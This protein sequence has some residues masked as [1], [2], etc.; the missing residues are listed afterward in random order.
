M[1]EIDSDNFSME[2]AKV[3][4][5][6]SGNGN[7]YNF[8]GVES[9]SI[10]NKSDEDIKSALTDSD[11]VFIIAGVQTLNVAKIAK[12]I[13]ALTVAIVEKEI[14]SSD[15]DTFFVVDD[16]N[17]SI[18]QNI[19]KSISDLIAVPGLINLDVTDVKDILGNAGRAYS[20]TGEA[21][22]TTDAVK[23]AIKSVDGNISNSKSLLLNLLGATDGLSMMEVN[24]AATALQ[25]AVNEDAEI[26]WGVSIEESLGDK[27]IATVIAARCD[28]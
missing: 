8:D 3:K 23:N 4:L 1:F 15:I 16:K 14:K 26:I 19:I 24:D 7:D 6:Y 17:K 9:V 22:N 5:A 10:D 18:F 27:I 2:L 25:E 21:E 28:E 20:G 11:L 12:E 13:G